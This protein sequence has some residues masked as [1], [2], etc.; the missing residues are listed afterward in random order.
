MRR[1]VTIILI[2]CCIVGCNNNE[3]INTKNSERFSER[4][5][6]TYGYVGFSEALSI[7]EDKK[8]GIKYLFYKSGHGGGLCK[9]YEEQ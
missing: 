4:F 1:V 6:V 2:C 9:L 3:D 8:T 7:I 5:I